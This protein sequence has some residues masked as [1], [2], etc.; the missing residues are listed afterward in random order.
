MP[1]NVD[2][3]WLVSYD[4]SPKKDIEEWKFVMS[5]DLISEERVNGPATL[6]RVFDQVVCFSITGALSK[7][8]STMIG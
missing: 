5:G 2:Y 1:I 3:R 8:T 7:N 6:G 4:R